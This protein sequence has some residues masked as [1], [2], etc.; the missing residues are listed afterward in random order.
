LAISSLYGLKEILIELIG[1][2]EIEEIEK[3]AASTGNTMLDEAVQREKT[4]YLEFAL[5]LEDKLGCKLTE[6]IEGEYIRHDPMMV[7]TTGGIYSWFPPYCFNDR[8]VHLVTRSA[9]LE[10]VRRNTSGTTSSKVEEFYQGMLKEAY[11]QNATDIHINPMEKSYMILFRID[12]DRVP[13]NEISRAEGSRLVDFIKNLC[14]ATSNINIAETRIPQDGRLEYPERGLDIRVCF[15]PSIYGY[16]VVMRLL[17]QEVLDDTLQSLGFME[18][19]IKILNVFARKSYGMVLVCGP[20]GSGKS[21]TLSTLLKMIDRRKKNVLTVEDPVEYRVWGANQGQIVRWTR[22]GREEGYTFEMGARAF[23]RA[24][25]DVCLVGEIRDHQTAVASF[26]LSNTGHLVFS[27]V[28]T[29]S[30]A[31]APAR[32]IQEPINL[33]RYTVANELLCVLGQRLVKKLCPNCRIKRPFDRETLEGHFYKQK[34]PFEMLV[35]QEFYT[36][37]PKG[38]KYCRNGYVGRTVVEEILVVTD[39]IKR[40]IIE[41]NANTYR[42]KEYLDITFS[43]STI[44]KAEQG[45]IDIFQALEVIPV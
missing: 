12:G 18:K 5:F 21:R 27:T 41:E 19:T 15:L 40:V 35:G 34:T 3:A 24:D 4:T 26:A 17:R 37:N 29:N 28:H 44:T 13:W 32:L 14:N 30:A 33:D 42:L 45:I 8:K 2:E 11:K 20:T 9:Y 6:D 36:A 43:E 25:P 7:E 16:S 38:C 10:Y 39:D 22:D 23:L 1:E 31:S